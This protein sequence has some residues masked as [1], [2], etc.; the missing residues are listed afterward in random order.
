MKPHF[1][2]SVHVFVHVELNRWLGDGPI[3]MTEILGEIQENLIFFNEYLSH[4][5]ANI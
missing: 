3:V 1:I 5:V 2:S 4:C